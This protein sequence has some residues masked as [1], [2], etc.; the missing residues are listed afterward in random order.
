MTAGPILYF[1]MAQQ[2]RQ[3]PKI[4]SSTL[5]Q[6]SWPSRNMVALSF[7]LGYGTPPTIRSMD[8]PKTITFKEYTTR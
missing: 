7:L 1:F 5:L 6:L 3:Q 8:V 2:P 4:L